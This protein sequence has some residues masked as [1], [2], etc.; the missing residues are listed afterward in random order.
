MIHAIRIGIVKKEGADFIELAEGVIDELWAEGR[1]SNSDNEDVFKDAAGRRCN[2]PG[3]DHRGKFLDRFDWLGDLTANFIIRSER[4]ISKPVVSYHATFIRVGDFSGFQRF[5]IGE[6]FLNLRLHFTLEIVR[7]IHS[8]EIEA[9][10]KVRVAKEGFGVF[11]EGHGFSRKELNG[12]QG[13]QERRVRSGQPV[14]SKMKLRR[15]RRRGL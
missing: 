6:S 12:C 1:S 7:N 14:R 2:F 15:C 11:F 4:G 13:A 10:P 3:R 9:E 5:E 8:G